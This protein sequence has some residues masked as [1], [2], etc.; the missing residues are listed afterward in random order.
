MYLW[1]QD[2]HKCLAACAALYVYSMNL[3]SD[4]GQESNDSSY[5][6]MVRLEGIRSFIGH[7]SLK[8]SLS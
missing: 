7:P 6:D 4:A 1:T 5:L 8:W 3:T 2:K